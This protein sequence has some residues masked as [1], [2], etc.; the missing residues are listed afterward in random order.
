MS[1]IN[2]FPGSYRAAAS[3]LTVSVSPLGLVEL[4]DEE[5]EVHGPRMNRYSSNWAWY[6]GHHHAYRREI[7]ESQLTFN[8]VKALSD[9]ITNFTFANGVH[10]DSPEATRAVVPHVLKEIWEDH[11]DKGSI[12]WETGQLG[13]VS[14]DVFVKVAYE[15]PPV[16][17]RGKPIGEGRYRILPLN[18]AYCFPEFHPHDRK[19]FL[20]FKL[21]Y[22]FWGTGADGTRQIFTYTELLT[23]ESVEEYI[24]DELIDQRPNVLGEIPIAYVPNQIVASSPWGLAD[25]NDIVALN[26]EYNEKGMEVSDIINYHAAPVTVVTGAK[27]SNLEKGP[28][29]VWAIGSKDAK[30]QNLQMDTNLAGPLGYME[31]IKTAMHEMTGVPAT[32]LGQMN[33]VTNTS[34]VAIHMQYLPLMQKYKQKK[35]QYTKLYKRVN[36]LILKTVAYHEPERLVYNPMVAGVPPD[37]DQMM[38]LEFDPNQPDPVW[39]RSTVDWPSPLPM[40][41]LIALN[42]IQ[43]KM[44]MG[45]QSKR[46]ALKQLGEG[47]PDQKMQEVFEELLEDTKTQGA[48]NLTSAQVAQ[49]I[50]QAT[51]MTPDGQPLVIP[52]TETTDAEGNPTGMAPQVNPELAQELIA[53]AFQIYPP[54]RSDYDEQA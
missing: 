2:F 18:P 48:L 13:S 31:M 51:G 4:A 6:L 46:G 7:G 45:I 39:F 15:P 35:I 34:G 22:K 1:G 23:D 36:E 14:G 17:D 38:Y 20:K 32:A 5:F 25:I 29:K 12:L 37:Q 26:R 8:Y 33:P 43:A 40:D 50:M 24:N 44:Q 28:R 42:E 21:K 11:N 49:I 30:V 9:Y 54:L 27:A 16:D 52:G 19:R 53:Q 41:E 3:D 10:F 47:F